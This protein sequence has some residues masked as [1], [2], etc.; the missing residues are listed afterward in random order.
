MA[1]DQPEGRE[2]DRTCGKMNIPT[3]EELEALGALRRIKERVRA[4]KEKMAA[5]SPSEGEKERELLDSLEKELE[6]LREEW[7]RWERKKEDAARERMIKLG[8]VER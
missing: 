8:H 1:N 5:I 4:I 6:R 3:D 7:R 2:Y